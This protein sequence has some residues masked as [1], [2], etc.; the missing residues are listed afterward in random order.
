MAGT[1]KSAIART[2]GGALRHTGLLAASF[3]CSRTTTALSDARKIVPTLSRTVAD[4]Y[5]AFKSALL[6][7]LKADPDVAHSSLEEQFKVLL[8][9]TFLI[10]SQEVSNTPTRVVILDAIDECADQMEVSRLI[11]L[12]TKYASLP[13]KFFITSRPEASVR[14]KLSLVRDG[15]ESVLYL[16]DIEQEVVR[17][18]IYK[19][20]HDRLAEIPENRND[21]Q[22][23]TEWPPPK[24]LDILV[25]RADNL[26]IFAFTAYLYISD[27]ENNPKRRLEELTS[28][29]AGSMPLVSLDQIYTFILA[30][31]LRRK[32]GR[33]SDEMLLVLRT[34]VTLRTTLCVA[35]IASLLDIRADRVRDALAGLH[36]LLSVP[37]ENDK[38]VVQTF[39][40]SF[41]DYLTEVTRSGQ[42]PWCV[43]TP[44]VHHGLT[45]GCHRVMN[46]YLKFNVCG[47]DT[48]HR[49]NAQ[50]QHKNA[51]R[52]DL[53]YSCRYWIDH[54]ISSVPGNYLA[55]NTLE[56][57]RSKFLYWL[58]VLSF[59][60]MA[61]DASVLLRKALVF[62]KAV[63]NV[64]FSWDHVV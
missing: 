42:H 11:T 32:H 46:V 31:A 28:Q 52:S 47:L 9:D 2:L 56:L 15:R 30:A 48:S 51:I 63:C 36:S 8:V 20:L 39:H 35:S 61:R 14:T 16:H 62:S 12:I 64:H 37:R 58:E 44:E 60:G 18:D 1:G 41:P 4:V 21:F 50:L 25:Q 10:S 49:K 5:P 3:F 59:L 53:T 17:K 7:A 33:D 55:T 23:A 13:I 38:G 34:I 19:Y 27:L 57:L 29:S 54:W 43:K 22:P 24:E 6:E 26:F 40:A 45:L